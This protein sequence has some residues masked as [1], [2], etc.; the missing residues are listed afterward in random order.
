MCQ[1]P[2]DSIA[3]GFQHGLL[4]GPQAQED[5]GLFLRVSA[6]AIMAAS[7]L[8]KF[9]EATSRASTSRWPSSTSIP[10]SPRVVKAINP[11][12]SQCVTLKCSTELSQDT[13][14]RGIS[15]QDNLLRS[16]F[17]IPGQ[18]QPQHARQSRKRN[19]SF[20]NHNVP[21]DGVHR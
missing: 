9:A 7:L 19:A 10:T 11:S 8:V 2:L 16:L 13:A 1:T 21:R 15:S 5:A 3:G 6:A 4:P 18:P 12:P 17:E 14:C 20:A